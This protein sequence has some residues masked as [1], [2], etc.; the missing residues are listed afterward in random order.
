VAL[1]YKIIIIILR[2]QLKLQHSHSSRAS[3]WRQVQTRYRLK[4]GAE[5]RSLPRLMMMTMMMMMSDWSSQI[6]IS[7]YY[8]Y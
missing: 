7:S 4:C 6:K 2:T 3:W 8:L 1:C 5:H